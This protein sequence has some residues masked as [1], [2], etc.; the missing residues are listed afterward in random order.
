MI[1]LIVSDGVGPPSSGDRRKPAVFYGTPM[2]PDKTTIRDARETI[3]NYKLQDK[4]PAAIVEYI[5][6]DNRVRETP[7][8]FD[9]RITIYLLGAV[10][11]MIFKPNQAGTITEAL[12][13]AQYMTDRNMPVIPS[14]RAGGVADAPEKEIGIARGM[15]VGKTGAPRGGARTGGL[16]Q[17]LAIAEEQSLP[18][19]NVRESHY[20]MRTKFK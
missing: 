17:L 14:G 4:I 19:L 20:F 18:V 5:F 16:N 6:D 10:G 11:G 15:C 1:S 13:A 3:I 9:D 8:R 7:K 12:K 2:A